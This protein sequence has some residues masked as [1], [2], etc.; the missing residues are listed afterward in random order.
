MKATLAIPLVCVVAAAWGWQPT[1]PHAPKQPRPVEPPAQ[2]EQAPQAA[3][4]VTEAE[5]LAR[6]EALEQRLAQAEKQIAALQGRG[7]ETTTAPR[8]DAGARR[9][10]HGPAGPG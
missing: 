8:P 3:T 9:S 7:S 6:I 2:T 10:S 4:P 5:L 1:T